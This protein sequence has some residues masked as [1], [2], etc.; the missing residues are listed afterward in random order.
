MAEFS[1]PKE[2]IALTHFIVSNDVE[3]S[4]RFYTGVL[5]G[6][7]VMEGEPTAHTTMPSR[8]T[9]PRAFMRSSSSA[10]ACRSLI[11]CEIIARPTPRSGSRRMSALTRSTIQCFR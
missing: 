7:T 8:S 6:E 9:K 5:G 3:R 1:A 2:G 4:R 11:V 10:S